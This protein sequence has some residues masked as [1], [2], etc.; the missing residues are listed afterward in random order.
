[1]SKIKIQTD[2][3]IEVVNEQGYDDV[4]RALEAHGYDPATADYSVE[5]TVEERLNA[6]EKPPRVL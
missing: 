4:E 3:G 2:D 5:L 1:M 6:L